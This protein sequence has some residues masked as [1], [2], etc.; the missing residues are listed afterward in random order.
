M[1]QNYITGVFVKPL[2]KKHQV[3]DI[4]YFYLYMSSLIIIY[5]AN[6]RTAHRGHQG[7]QREAGQPG[8][9]IILGH[10]NSNI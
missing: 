6:M 3:G 2:N 10:L 7:E 4:I 8:A 1:S 9:F 5:N